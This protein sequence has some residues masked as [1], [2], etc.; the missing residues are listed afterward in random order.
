MFVES[1]NLWRRAAPYVEYN[2]GWSLPS[3]VYTEYGG[4]WRPAAQSLYYVSANP[5]HQGAF[6]G[7]NGATISSDLWGWVNGIDIGYGPLNYQW[8]IFSGPGTIVSGANSP[9][10]NVNSNIPGTTRYRCRVTD[11]ITSQFVD[12]FAEIE[13]T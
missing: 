11:S 3:I 4:V 2:G 12:A 6:F 13:W 9:T 7:G 5:D 8:I 1:G 10:V